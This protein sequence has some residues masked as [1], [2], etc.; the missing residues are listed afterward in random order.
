[1]GAYLA[2]L[3]ILV[4]WAYAALR[5]EPSL[6]PYAIIYEVHSLLGLAVEG[7]FAIALDVYTFGGY[8][9]YFLVTLGI[10]PLLG[11]LYARYSHHRPF[12]RAVLGGAILGGP[13]ELLFLQ[14]GAYRF[15]RGWHPM[16]TTL[17]FTGYFIW[18][19]WLKKAISGSE[20]NA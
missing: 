12:F 19:W 17:F 9:N 1:M 5:N 15:H 10:E 16:L 2:M 6:R 14:F 8:T 11:V 18:T 7:L 20:K 4:A 13:V 3:I